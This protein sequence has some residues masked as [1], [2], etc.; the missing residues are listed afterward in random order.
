MQHRREEGQ[1]DSS[2]TRIT[3]KAQ[4]QMD[5]AQVKEFDKGDIQG[6]WSTHHYPWRNVPATAVTFP[7]SDQ[8]TV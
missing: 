3:K 5:V 1:K 2:S 6:S 4:E 7:P 8:D